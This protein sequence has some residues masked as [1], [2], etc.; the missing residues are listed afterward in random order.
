MWKHPKK[1]L[2]K[3]KLNKLSE[4]ELEKRDMRI[5]RGG[6]ECHVNCSNNNGLISADLFK[7]S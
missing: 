7:Y 2:G 5:L 1:T 4:N 6:C 3:L